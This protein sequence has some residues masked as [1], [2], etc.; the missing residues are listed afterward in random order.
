MHGATHAPKTPAGYG[1]YLR[2]LY[3]PG[4]LSALQHGAAYAALPANPLGDSRD[5]HESAPSSLDYC[6]LSSASCLRLAPH[7]RRAGTL[8]GTVLFATS[9]DDYAPHPPGHTRVSPQLTL[10]QLSP[11]GTMEEPSDS[12]YEKDAENGW[13]WGNHPL[14]SA[15]Q[16]SQLCRTVTSMKHAFAYSMADLPGYCG[17]MGPCEIMLTTNGHIWVPQR[18]YS[19][20]ELEIGDEKV[21]E[22]REAT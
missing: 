11:E 8:G 16:L 13:V 15:R 17:K 4:A 12:R 21:R 6:R 10:D 9:V 2:A 7:P 18:R 20:R 22:L 19:L 3:A 14:A 1:W 5:C